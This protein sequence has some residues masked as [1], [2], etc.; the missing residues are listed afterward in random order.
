MSKSGRFNYTSNNIATV[1]GGGNSF[2]VVSLQMQ[3]PPR[4]KNKINRKLE[5]RSF[6]R[7]RRQRANQCIPVSFIHLKFDHNI[8]NLEMKN[9]KFNEL[10]L[11]PFHISTILNLAHCTS[12]HVACEVP[13]R[14]GFSQTSA[15]FSSL[16]QAA[17]PNAFFNQTLVFGWWK[18]L[19]FCCHIFTMIKI[20]H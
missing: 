14:C 6:H 12:H 8:Y 16:K 18:K 10:C 19:A 9:F 1:A 17:T 2:F 5:G 11:Y 15:L 13:T 20:T 7:H 4:M 3:F